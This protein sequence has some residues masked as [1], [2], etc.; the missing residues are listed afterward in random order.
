MS[1]DQVIS[2]LSRFTPSFGLDRDALLFAAGRASAPASRRWRALAGILAVSQLVVLAMLLW[3]RPLPPSSGPGPALPQAVVVE[4]APLPPS[5]FQLW[6]LR[7]LA[8]ETDGNLPPSPSIDWP[9]SAEPPLRV[10][11]VN[12]ILN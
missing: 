1:D 5:P 7:E 9:A 3:P 8:L 10:L 11:D 4:Q 6:N 2:R 12:S